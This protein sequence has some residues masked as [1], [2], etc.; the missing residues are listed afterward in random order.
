MIA[1]NKS[2][3]GTNLDIWVMD[4]NG[5]NA[6]QLTSDPAS[7]LIPSWFPDN[8]RI[9]FL[10]NRGGQ[11]AIWSIAE[12]TKKETC[13]LRSRSDLDIDY[14]QVSPDGKYFAFASKRDGAMNIWRADINSG[15]LKQVTFDKEMMSFPCWSPDGKFLAPDSDKIAFA[16]LR[17]GFW[18]IYWVSR[19][20]G[21]QHQITNY[22]KLNAYVRYPAWSPR[23]DRI[24]Y[25][26]A[27]TTGNIWMIENVQ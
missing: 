22:N 3:P 15:E 16:G 9:A 11:V 20:T 17:D 14:P 2:L 1:F 7:D 5:H 6:R 18:N 4:A 19:S 12:K 27:E 8:D 25:E 10:S 24:V 21:E 26:Y 13:W 23:G